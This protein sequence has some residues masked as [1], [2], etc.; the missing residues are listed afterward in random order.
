VIAW[1]YFVLGF[2]PAML[3]HEMGHVG[4]GWLEGH[5]D[6]VIR[7]GSPW[8]RVLATVRC[9]PVVLQFH[10]SPAFLVTPPSYH[11]ARPAGDSALAELVRAAAGPAASAILFLLATPD[12]Q[13][14]IRDLLH[15]SFAVNSFRSAVAFWGAIGALLPLIPMTYRSPRVSSDGLT[16]VRSLSRL[17]RERSKTA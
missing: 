15:F 7:F 13:Q 2:F 5:R 16:V 9:G 11:F 1:L 3:V 17:L 10:A 8:Q 6:P 12:V 4:V 14:G